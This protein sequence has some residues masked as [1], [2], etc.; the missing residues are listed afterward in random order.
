MA[1]PAIARV[2]DAGATPHGRPYFVMEYVRGEPITTYCDVI[3]CLSQIASPSSYRCA[4]A[5]S[6]R[7]RKALSTAT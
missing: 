5:F 2:F 1:H 7:I 4:R 6:M 3:S